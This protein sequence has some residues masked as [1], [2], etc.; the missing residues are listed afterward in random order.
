MDGKRFTASKV[1]NINRAII[2]CFNRKLLEEELKTIENI[3]VNNG[4]KKEIVQKFPRKRLKILNNIPPGQKQ[5][6]RFHILREWQYF[7]K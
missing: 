4:F 3:A 6:N 5:L 2:I 1:T 7:E